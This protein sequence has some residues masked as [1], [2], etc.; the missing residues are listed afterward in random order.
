MVI[1]LFLTCLNIYG[2]AFFYKEELSLLHLLF[3]IFVSMDL[4]FFKNS[5]L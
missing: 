5:V 2:L 4:D 3:K 1:F